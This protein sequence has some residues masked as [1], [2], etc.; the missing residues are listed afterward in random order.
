[1]K[2]DNKKTPK[3]PQKYYCEKCDFL[4][5][6]RRDFNR[7][8]LTRKH[9]KTPNNGKNPKMLDFHVI[10]VEKFINIKAVYLGTKVK[11]LAQKKESVEE[12][13]VIKSYHCETEKK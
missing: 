2:N 11:C 10:S 5:S 3:K 8:L 9:E 4:S 6:N 13:N 7:H 12:D 1:M